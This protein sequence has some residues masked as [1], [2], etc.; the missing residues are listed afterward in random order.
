MN[1]KNNYKIRAY[2]KKY[3]NELQKNHKNSGLQKSGKITRV[4][5][6]WSYV[7][8]N[9]LVLHWFITDNV[10]FIQGILSFLCAPLI[11]A[12]SDVW[13]RKSFLLV[14]VFSTCAPIPLLYI[15][16]IAYFIA[17]ALSGALAVTFSIVFSYVAD[18]TDEDSRSCAY[19]LVCSVS[20]VC[21]MCVCVCVCVRVCVC[22]HVDVQVYAYIFAYIHF[23]MCVHT[24]AGACICAHMHVS[25]SACMSVCLC[26]CVFACM[27]VHAH[28]CVSIHEY[29]YSMCL[30][31]TGSCIS[32]IDCMTLLLLLGFQVSAMFAASLVIS[33]ALGTFILEEY[34]KT[35]M[36][37]V[38]SLATG[39][40]IMNLLFIIFIVPES[41]REGT[42]K[43]VWGNSIT[44][45]QADPFSVSHPSMN[46]TC[47][48]VINN[49]P[50]LL[51]FKIL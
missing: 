46:F 34:P 4:K 18:C 19:G 26:L 9:R 14:T 36:F 7:Y 40:T 50:L 32:Y 44:C 42:R 22:A 16:G 27:Y 21:P 12:L 15:N 5:E 2:C 23:C 48:K 37:N 51:C 43:S 47:Y 11:G 33:P 13:G 25:V 31:S 30:H 3:L 6:I 17:V 41:L 8:K 1:Y 35:G 24:H 20:I 39:I 38:V 49:F 10:C 29:S 28:M 45:E